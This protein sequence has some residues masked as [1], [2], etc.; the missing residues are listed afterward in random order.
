MKPVYLLPT[1]YLLDALVGDPEWFPHPVRIIGYCIDGGER[2]LRRPDDTQRSEFVKGALLTAVIVASSYYATRTAIRFAYARARV[3][4]YAAELVLGWTCIAA[5]NLHQEAQA[6]SDAL[7]HGELPQARLR[8]SRI[9]GRDTAALDA[10]EISRALIETLAES[11]SDGILAPLL[12]IAVGGVPLAMAYK[13]INTL[14]SMIGH[15]DD[16][17]LYFGKVAARIDDA[18]NLVPSRTTALCTIGAAALAPCGNLRNSW[19]TWRSDGGKHKSPNAGQPEAA[20]AGALGV[21]LGGDNYYDGQLTGA[22]HIGKSFPQPTP[23]KARQAIQLTSSI[24]II[25][26][27]AS[28]LV[29]LVLRRQQA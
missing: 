18:A 1:A 24:A 4:G 21:R 23:A 15:H 17:Y 7:E 22:Q 2:F 20:M 13:A 14:D 6:V 9:V 29:G 3:V 26:L 5:R 25:G 28:L 19:N 11:A 27:G 10:H 16:R 12:Y 8:L